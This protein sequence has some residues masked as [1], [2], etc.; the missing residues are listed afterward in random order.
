MDEVSEQ[1]DLASTQRRVQPV[2]R[3]NESDIEIYIFG[4]NEERELRTV[5]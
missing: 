2:E 1:L 5:V 3:I 4:L